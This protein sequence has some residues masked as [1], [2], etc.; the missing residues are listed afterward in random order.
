MGAEKEVG[1]ER[2]T[3]GKDKSTEMFSSTGGASGGAWNDVGI[4]GTG[5]SRVRL[6][7]SFWGAPV[8]V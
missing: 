5:R 7:S 1:N 6:I 4:A 3:A 8:V 2:L